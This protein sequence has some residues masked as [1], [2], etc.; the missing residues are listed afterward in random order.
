MAA[1]QVHCTGLSLFHCFATVNCH[2]KF[3][4]LPFELKKPSDFL[5]GFS[6]VADMGATSNDTGSTF[7]SCHLVRTT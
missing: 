4:E 5:H 7:P 1:D 6:R 2:H 3:T